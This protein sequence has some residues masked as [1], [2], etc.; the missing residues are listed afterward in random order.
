MVRQ[1]LPLGTWGRIWLTPKGRNPKGRPAAYRARATYRGFDGVSTRVEA[2]GRTQASAEANLLRKLRER[3]AGLHVGVLSPTT[4]FAVASELW[5][6]RVEGMVEDGRRSPTTLETYQR[7]LRGHVLPALGEVRLGELTTPVVDRFLSDVKIR[8]SASTARTCR[9]VV[10]GVLGLA[11]RHGALVS[12]PVRD[13]EH[14]EST[15]KRRARALDDQERREWFAMLASDPRAAAADLP[16]LTLF[17]L[18]TGARIGEALGVKWED[19]DLKS[20]E[21]DIG[22][23]VIRVAG[24]GLVRSRTKSRAGERLLRLPQWAVDMLIRRAEEGVRLEEPVFCTALGGFRDPSNV[25][26]SLREVRAPVGSEARQELGTSLARARHQA[27]LS[28]REVAATMNMPRTRMELIE[29]GRVRVEPSQVMDLAKLYG[30]SRVVRT[31]LTRLAKEAAVVSGAD[32]MSWITS[33]TF[34]K[35]T[36]T[37]LDDAGHSARQ[38]ADQL[39]HARPSMTQDVYMGRRSRNPAAAKSLE[40]AFEVPP[41]G[42]KG[43]VNGGKF[44]AGEEPRAPSTL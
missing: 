43:G 15:V 24:R 38:I 36:A 32:A 42:Q 34:R 11:V 39:G 9:T 6:K 4:R 5:L 27:G 35:T 23:Q 30:A 16:D 44:E 19:V 41:P 31:Q 40:D 22:H 7:Q 3:R 33:H 18:A 14:L 20:E 25:R 29:Q 17:M 10:S 26:R 28:R 1:P 8:V 13:A 12:N 21:V 2:E 37:I